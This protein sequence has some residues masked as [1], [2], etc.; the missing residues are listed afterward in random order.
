[1]AATISSLF[2]ISYWDNS[3]FSSSGVVTNSEVLWR[4]AAS[5]NVYFKNLLSIYIFYSTKYVLFQYSSYFIIFYLLLTWIIRLEFFLAF[6]SLLDTAIV[7]S[8]NF[9]IWASHNVEDINIFCSILEIKEF[10]KFR[11]RG[12]LMICSDDF[13]SSIMFAP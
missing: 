10:N 6:E 1:M 2:E 4:G 5:L 13:F 12:S 3:H 9:F 11:D 7:I 8:F